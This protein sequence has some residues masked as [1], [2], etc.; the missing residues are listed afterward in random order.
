MGSFKMGGFMS[1]HAMSRI[2]HLA[3][4]E[5][6]ISLPAEHRLVATR[7]KRSPPLRPQSGPPS[8]RQTVHQATPQA[9]LVGCSIP[10]GDSGATAMLTSTRCPASSRPPEGLG[11]DW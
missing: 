6:I 9:R 10:A 8:R 4:N 5:E 11:L 2:G 3:G 7:G 1:F